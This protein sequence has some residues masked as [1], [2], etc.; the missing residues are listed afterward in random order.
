[1]KNVQ[2]PLHYKGLV[3]SET[4][5]LKQILEPGIHFVWRKEVRL[6]PDDKVISDAQLVKTIEASVF[7]DQFRILNVK[8]GEILIEAVR[9]VLNGLHPAGSYALPP[10]ALSVTAL[11]AD[12]SVCDIPEHIPKNWLMKPPLSGL[13]RNFVVENHEYACL[14]IDG[15]EDRVLEP[16]AHLFFRNVQALDVRRIDKREQMAELS[17]QELL[18]ADKTPLRMSFFVRYQVSDPHKVLTE[19]RDYEKQLHTAMQFALREVC[20]TRTLDQLLEQKDQVAAEMLQAMR[21]KAEALGVHVTD[22]GIR[23]IILPGEIREIMNQVLVAEKKAQAAMITRREETAAMRAML[24][25]ARLMEDNPML[26]RLK[27]FEHIEKIA[28]KIE[29]IALQGNGHVLDQLKELFSGKS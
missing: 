15:K 7:A 5:E 6:L 1:M 19:L 22:G 12:T 8:D 9:G 2:V 18:S 11:I 3:F 26:Y 24:N 10:R 20:G 17:G 4:G 25:S 29:Y 27:E 21:S 14:F 13:V 23:D 28:E 16:G